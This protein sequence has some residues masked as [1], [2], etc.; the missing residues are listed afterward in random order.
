[1]IPDEHWTD[2]LGDVVTWL[3]SLVRGVDSSLLAEWE[4]LERLS[5][6]GVGASEPHRSAGM[7]TDSAEDAKPP[8]VPLSAN[9]RRLMGLIREAMA[10]RVDLLAREAYEE[11][12]ALDGAKGW[13][14]S[15][16]EKALAPY[17][18]EYSDIGIGPESRSPSMTMVDK[19]GDVWSIRHVLDDP[20]GDR[21]WALSAELSLSAS[22]EADALVM[23]MSGLGPMTL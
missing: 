23:T 7:S 11:L 5:G 8:V 19:R 16:W 17:W 12:G 6:E 18:E 10:R 20:E 21:D 14:A 9:P 4:E 15:R 3:G 22:D 13:D 1:M 2:E